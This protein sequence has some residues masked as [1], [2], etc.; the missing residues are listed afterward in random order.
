[1]KN[2]LEDF[3]Y[4][5]AIR[6][7]G[8][9]GDKYVKLMNSI[10]KSNI[11]PKHI[12]VVLP[13][14]YKPPNII[15]GTEQFIFS[16]KG[17]VPQRLEA[18]KY[19]NTEYVLFCDDDVE[20]NSTFIEKLANPLLNHEFSCAAGPLLEF[21]PPKEIKYLFASL[22]GGACCMIHGRKD[23]YVRILGT[24]GWSYNYSINI[25]ICKIYY[26]ES[27]PGTCFMVRTKN[28]IDA[29]LEDELWC[30]K[31]GYSA[32]EDRIMITKFLSNGNKACIVS[33]AVYIHNDGKTSTKELKLEPIYAGTFNHYVYW[34][35]FLYSACQ[36]KIKKFWLRI[37]ISY[38]I[39]MAKV[40]NV[41]L[42]LMKRCSKEAYKISGQG[43]KDAKEYV[44][45]EEY[46]KL[47]RIN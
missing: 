36:S 26:T 6:T 16:K 20:F 13:E 44:K 28:I 45:T 34:H 8:T 4:S 42:L 47:P 5:V 21:F 25:K 41:I 32:F 11:Q 29:H 31:S 46:L 15:L 37:C 30:E 40:Y 35:R 38:Y 19:I 24:G 43:F 39:S 2:I 9:A 22:L 33:D 3:D 10:K 17:M 27:L 14:G 23:T 1:M 7:L 12:F 18:L